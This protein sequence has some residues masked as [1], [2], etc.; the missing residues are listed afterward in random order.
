MS[1]PAQTPKPFPNNGQRQLSAKE[2]LQRAKALA[3]TLPKEKKP[4]CVG[5]VFVGLFFDGTG[6][7]M[8]DHYPKHGHS[9]VVRLFN[10]YPNKPKDGFYRY[11]I[12]GVGTPFP[13]IDEN[14]YS[15]RGKGLA[16]GGEQRINWGLVQVYNAV[17]RFLMADMNLISKV[18]AKTLVSNM[19]SDQL[20]VGNAYRRMVMSHWE[21]KLKAVI[22]NTKPEV[23]QINISVF[24]FSRG[25]AE[26]RAFCNWFFQLCEEKGGGYT[27]AGVPV[28]IYFL[29][30]FDTVA[31]VG[32]ANMYSLFEGHMA[33]ADDNMHI[34]PAVE[35][36]VHFVAAHEIRACF[37]LDSARSGSSY[38]A[39]CK[40]VVYP[41]AHSNVG[42]GYMPKAQGK[43]GQVP[44][45]KK[46]NFLALIAG[47]DMYHEARKA[48]VPLMALNDMPPLIRRDFEP[49]P[50]LLKAYN[51]YLH[52][53]SIGTKPVET[54]LRAH[55]G[56]YYRY[57]RLRLDN[58][59]TVAPY[60]KADAED[61]K[62]LQLTNE[63]FR[64]EVRL[65][66]ATDQSNKDAARDPVAF[67]KRL[68]H[69][70]AYP[71]KDNVVQLPRK[72]TPMEQDM[73]SAL[74][75]PQP[76][77]EEIVQFFDHY[78]HDSLAGFA[79]DGVREYTFNG[80]GHLRHRK[81]FVENG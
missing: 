15:S 71:S 63:D 64:K 10:A 14:S 28:R 52:K 19:S 22:K 75:H 45:E 20:G 3:C 66:E 59:L 55:M 24:G 23:Q 73:L 78:V 49:D 46:Y 50:D 42:G 53:S 76:L 17:H 68:Q 51:A 16:A 81:V 1:S 39:N 35:Q 58:L 65:L 34:N 31:S 13:E 18:Q 32:L 40:E 74:K 47:I 25:A 41:G 5:S 57:R 38:P 7:N 37:P 36:C 60:D 79:Q 69:A 6:N 33:W 21:E 67:Q 9:N 12:P 80:Q 26:A 27:F 44:D 8:L 2:Q 30:I 62:F 56:L 70:L 72:L 54:A 11:Y 77:S 4:A 61:R 29:G 43:S 48:G